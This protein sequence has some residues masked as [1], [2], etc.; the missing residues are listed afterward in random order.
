MTNQPDSTRERPVW[1]T[2]DQVQQ[3]LPPLG[4]VTLKNLASETQH[5]YTH[6]GGKCWYNLDRCEQYLHERLKHE[7]A[8]KAKSASKRGRPRLEAR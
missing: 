2:R 3:F 4:P 5:L 1:V 7:A 6:V 8:P